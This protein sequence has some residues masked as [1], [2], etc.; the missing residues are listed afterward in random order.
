MNFGLYILFTPMS[1]VKRGIGYHLSIIIS[2]RKIYIVRRHVYV[3]F[4][5]S[6]T[7]RPLDFLAYC[8]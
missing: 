8:P 7:L 1:P 4:V 5:C 2:S 6:A 3:R